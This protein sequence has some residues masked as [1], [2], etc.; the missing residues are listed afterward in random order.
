VGIDYHFKISIFQV[1]SGYESET[2]QV[3]KEQKGT[4]PYIFQ[5]FGS[6]D[7]DLG[8]LESGLKAKIKQGINRRYLEMVN[9]TP[10]IGADFTLA[11]RI[12]YSNLSDTSFQN[13]FVIDGKRITLEQFSEMLQMVEGFNAS[14]CCQRIIYKGP[15]LDLACS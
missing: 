4:E 8:K 11:G 12:D 2:V 7:A 1:P 6:F 5:V 9:G 13:V 14:L 15:D 10:V 3:I